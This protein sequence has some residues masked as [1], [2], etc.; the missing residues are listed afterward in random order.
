[1]TEKFSAAVNLAGSF[2][3]PRTLVHCEAK[4]ETQRGGGEKGGVGGVVGRGWGFGG[5][6]KLAKGW[7]GGRGSRQ[8][9][10]HGVTE[11]NVVS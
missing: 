7:D 5:K 6:R 9:R 3:P 10:P 4:Q 1:M 8:E 11:D 2:F